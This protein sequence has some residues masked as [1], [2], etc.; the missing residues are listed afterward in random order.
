MQT[1]P[2]PVAPVVTPPAVPP[3]AGTPPVVP[4]ATPVVP[5]VADPAAPVVPPV[6]AAELK[7]EKLAGYPESEQARVLALAK[8]MGLDQAAA[9]KL[10]DREAAAFKTDVEAVTRELAAKQAEFL[11]VNKSHATY[12]GAKFEETNTRINQLLAWGGDEGKALASVLDDEGVRQLPA[13]HNFLARVA[14]QMKDGTFIQ[15][16][17][18]QPDPNRPA[19]LSEVYPSMK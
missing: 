4:P 2:D 3:V 10:H 17:Q 9:Q 16:V 8:D 7:F 15:G 1:M 18:S 11:A 12:G 13:I 6:V 19:T 5:P 14:Y